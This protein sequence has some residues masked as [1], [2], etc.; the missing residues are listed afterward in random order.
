[1]AR[2]AVF[3]VPMRV[4]FRGITVRE[5]LLVRGD[6]GWGEFSPFLEYDDQEARPWLR[7]A[8]E[9]ADEG[10]PAP[11][12]DTIPVNVTVPAVGPEQAAAV[13]TNSAGCRTAKVKVA[14]GPPFDDERFRSGLAQDVAR[15]RVV[16]ESLG[17]GGK[18]RI[19][20]NAGWTVEQAERALTE[21]GEFDLEPDELVALLVDVGCAAGR[22]GAPAEF[23]LL[24][25]KGDGCGQKRK[26]GGD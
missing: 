8:R 15:V 16:R 22:V 7:A 21:L 20:A 14:E 26:G 17:P 9:A 10:W 4:R 23:L 25:G 6:A 24:L 13:V 12:R 19:D 11:L 2:V 5:G 18:V 1:M 3:A